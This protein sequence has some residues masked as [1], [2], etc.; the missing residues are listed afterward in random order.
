MRVLMMISNSNTPVRELYGMALR[1]HYPNWSLSNMSGLPSNPGPIVGAYDALIYELGAA[2]DPTRYKAALALW[3]E[4]KESGATRMVT[5]IEGPF[6]DGVVAELEGQGIVCVGAPFTPENVA[7]ALDRIA[8]TPRKRKGAGESSR[9]EAE[10]G[11]RG[12][13]FRGLFRRRE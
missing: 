4:V 9:K 10:T 6:R 11:E 7:A 3:D 13:L 2:N 8:P 5:H 1:D 12:G